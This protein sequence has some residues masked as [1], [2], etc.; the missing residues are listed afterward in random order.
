M[1]PRTSL[2]LSQAVSWSPAGVPERHGLPPPILPSRRIES[3]RPPSGRRTPGAH[4]MA[5][6][7]LVLGDHAPAV[8]PDS[9]A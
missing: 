3:R 1:I 5:A 4:E 7:G 8:R 9:G 6:N 2:G